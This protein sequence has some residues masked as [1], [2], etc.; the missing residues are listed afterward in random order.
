[1]CIVVLK[2]CMF[3]AHTACLTVP[4]SKVKVPRLKQRV[5]LLRKGILI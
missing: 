2:K 1:M 3:R 5:V 4:Q